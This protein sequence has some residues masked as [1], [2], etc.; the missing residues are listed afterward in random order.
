[1]QPELSLIIPNRNHADK[2]PRLLDS[3]L[4]QKGVS[5][6][7][8]IV[9][10]CSDQPYGELVEGCRSRGLNITLLGHDQRL[11]TKNARLAGIRAAK[12]PVIAFADADDALVGTETL[13]THLKLMRDQHAD[14]VHFR[15]F[16]SDES[17]GF[18]RYF[19]TADPFAEKLTGRTE[20]FEHFLDADIYG[21][22]AIWNK[23]F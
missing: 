18:R 4:A 22:S 14:V 5:L 15:S 9:D 17:G 2:L 3:V 6:E 20:I 12:A 13:S 10:D 16:I 1:M 21:T 19:H 8:V 23:F 11:Y 7:L